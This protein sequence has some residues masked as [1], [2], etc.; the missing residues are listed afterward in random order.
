MKWQV[1]ENNNQNSKFCDRKYDFYQKNN[2]SAKMR[3][4]YNN[5]SFIY[6]K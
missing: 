5:P 4:D 3:K 6:L 1:T 2:A